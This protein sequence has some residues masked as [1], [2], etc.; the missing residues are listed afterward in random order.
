MIVLQSGTIGADLARLLHKSPKLP[1]ALGTRDFVRAVLVVK[2]LA[3]FAPHNPGTASS[4]EM[5]VYV[6]V[7]DVDVKLLPTPIPVSPVDCFIVHSGLAYITYDNI[8][9]R[10]IRAFCL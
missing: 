3:R 10:P 6:P 7:V 1:A 9:D 4:T 5:L 2:C 8:A